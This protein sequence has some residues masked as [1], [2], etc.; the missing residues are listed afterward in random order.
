MSSLIG[1]TIYGHRMKS[2]LGKILEASIL[3]AAQK[4]IEYTIDRFKKVD[5]ENTKIK[6]LERRIGVLEN[7][8][9]DLESSIKSTKTAVTK[10]KL[11]NKTSAY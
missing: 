5:Q 2:K 8:C 3:V 9:S 1:I 6:E 7:R 11:G 10:A 4:G